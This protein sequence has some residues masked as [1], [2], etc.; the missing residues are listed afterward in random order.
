MTEPARAYWNR[1]ARRYADRPVSDPEAY[2]AALAR[3]RAHLPPGARVLELGCGT[4]TTALRLAD[5]ATAIEACDF[6]EEMIAI[7]RE[8]AA[9]AEAD[10]VAF[11]CADPLAA[12]APTS[13]FDA[14]LAFNLLHLIDDLDGE[15]A[16]I[17]ARLRPGGVFISKTVCLREVGPH[18][19]LAVWALRRFGVLPPHMASF[20]AAALE[21]RIAG[22]GFEILETG[23][24]PKSPPGRLIVARKPAD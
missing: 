18:L 15:L 5:A 14:V 2:D 10:T 16:A 7:A 6:S 3:V 4:G 12:G 1:V 17:R 22:A 21:R 9:A 24:Y 23:T 20:R 13:E 19:R 11:R 8:R